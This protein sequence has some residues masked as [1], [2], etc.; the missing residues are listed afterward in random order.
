[1]QNAGDHHLGATCQHQRAEQS[2]HHGR[3][4]S[5]TGFQ[6]G[7]AHNQRG[8]KV[9]AGALNRQQ[10]G[11]NRTPGLNLNNRCHTGGKQ[12]HTNNVLRVLCR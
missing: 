5:T 10:P 2:R 7:T 11:A 3:N 12:R 8:N 1:M 4:I 6:R 9:E